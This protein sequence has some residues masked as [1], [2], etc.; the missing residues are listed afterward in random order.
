MFIKRVLF[1]ISSSLL[2]AISLPFSA[3]GAADNI[4]VTPAHTQGWSETDTRTGGQ[5]NYVSDADAP[6]GTA[7]LQLMTDATD[8][9]KAQYMHS[10]N[11]NL[12]DVTDISYY[13]K[14]IGASFDQG[15]PSYQIPIFANG[16]SGF[17]TLV[18]EPYLNGTVTSG[19]WQNWDVSAGKFWSSRDVTCSNGSLTKSAGSTLYTLQ[20]ISTACPSAKVLG[21][22]VNVGTS[23]PSYNVETDLVSFNGQTFD[24]ELVNTPSDKSACQNNGWKDLTGSNGKAFKNQGDCTSFKA[25]AG[26]NDAAGQ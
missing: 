5:L 1:S 19:D 22:G 3:A 10:A 16:N 26:R 24:F 13:T 23:N 25:T 2:L 6:A 11:V 21:F 14:Q 18:Y 17:A 15:A 4:V 8:E 7:A 9:A 20:D 12:A